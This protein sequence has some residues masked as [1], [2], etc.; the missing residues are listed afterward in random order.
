MGRKN[1]RRKSQ[2]RR[3][4]KTNPKRLLSGNGRAIQDGMKSQ[5]FQAGG[6]LPQRGDIWFAE[7]G[8]H[9]GTSIQEGCR[10]AFILSNDIGNLHSGIL[11]VVPLTSRIKKAY[12][13]THTLVSSCDCP[14]LEPSMVLGEQVTTISKAALKNYVGRVTESKVHEIEKAVGTHLG[15][16]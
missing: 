5:I 6:I 8:L 9:P 4:M 14:N 13:P 11:T 12:L 1:R 7:F 15:I 3:K 10:P 2:Y 16:G